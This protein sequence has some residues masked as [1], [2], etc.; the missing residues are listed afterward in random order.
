[1]LFSSFKFLT[2]RFNPNFSKMIL[3][4]TLILKVLHKNVLL[5]HLPPYNNELP[6]LIHFMIH[7]KIKRRS[8]IER[9]L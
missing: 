2:L 8:N 5:T 7:A 1:M 6:N 9:I 3:I 4:F